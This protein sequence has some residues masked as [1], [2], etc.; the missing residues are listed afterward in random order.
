[1]GEEPAVGLTREVLEETGVEVR[2]ESF[3][4]LSVTDPVVYANGDQA[5]YVDLCFVCRP[6]DP[7]S[8]E[9]AHVADDESSAVG[10]FATDDLPEPMAASSRDRLAWTLTF[11]TDPTAGPRFAH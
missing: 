5:R 8:A 4:A 7:E 11:L 1:P 9:R 2:V 3:S 10:W 6:A